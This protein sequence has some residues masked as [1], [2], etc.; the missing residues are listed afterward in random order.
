MFSK[1]FKQL[2]ILPIKIYRIAFTPFVGNVC[3]FYP[4]CSHYAEEAILKHGILKGSGLTFWRL[5]RCA[6]WS[7]GGV[8]PVP[9]RE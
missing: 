9:E 1:F 5:L 4:S 3:R 6:P 2:F 8:D 7:K